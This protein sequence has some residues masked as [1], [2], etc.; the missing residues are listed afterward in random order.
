[1]LPKTMAWTLTAVPQSPRDVVQPAIDLARS[2][3]PALEHGVDGAP[4]LFL[5]ILRERLAQR[6]LDDGL[7]LADQR[8]PMSRFEVKI[9]VEALVF[10]DDLQR[11]LEQ[12][13]GRCPAPRREYIWMKRR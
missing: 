5:R 8:L 3:I 10:L 9:G 11:V 2:C 6:L 1:M 4:Q 13:D 7:V 12:V